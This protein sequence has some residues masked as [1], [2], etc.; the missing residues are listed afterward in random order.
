[1][2]AD[3]HGNPCTLGSGPDHFTHQ[4]VLPVRL[5]PAHLRGR[6]YPVGGSLYSVTSC[7]RA[8]MS[9]TSLLAVTAAA[10]AAVLSPPTWLSTIPRAGVIVL[11]E[12]STSCH[13]SQQFRDAEARCECNKYASACGFAEFCQLGNLCFAENDRLR[14]AL[15]GL[16][17]VPRW[18]SCLSFPSGTRERTSYT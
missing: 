4:R 13:C 5:F 6:E 18:G 16:A 14:A 3:V 15:R 2:P 11:A 7:Q 1:M 9:V 12:K 10:E 17:H 8:S